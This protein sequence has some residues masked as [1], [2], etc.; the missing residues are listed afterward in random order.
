MGI[1][2]VCM[3]LTAIGIGHGNA[4]DVPDPPAIRNADLIRDLQLRDSVADYYWS[5]R[6]HDWAATYAYRRKTFQETVP[7]DFYVKEME[8]GSDGVDLQGLEI[9]RVTKTSSDW[10]GPS[11]EIEI[12]FFEWVTNQQRLEWECASDPACRNG[13]VVSG[14]TYPTVWIWR[15][16]RWKCLDCGRWVTYPSNARFV[17][18][19]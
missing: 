13:I 15:D 1:A 8:S 12:R 2:F 4:A 18:S 16:G 3:I 7:F 6:K 5:E 9:L 14:M 17:S 19:E 11:V 10:V